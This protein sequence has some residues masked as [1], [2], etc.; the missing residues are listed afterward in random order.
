MLRLTTLNLGL[1]SNSPVYMSPFKATMKV[2]IF[3]V[4]LACPAG[5]E[6]A[7]Y[8]LEGLANLQNTILNNGLQCPDS[9]VRQNRGHR[10]VEWGLVLGPLYRQAFVGKTDKFE[11]PK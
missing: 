2:A 8:G 1:V 10:G 9:G 4:H 6:P 5:V 7:T 3:L 11:R